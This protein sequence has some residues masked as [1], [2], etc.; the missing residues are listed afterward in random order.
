MRFKCFL[1]AAAVLAVSAPAGATFHLMSIREVYVGPAID[2]NA[3]Y[4]MLQMYA[5]DQNHVQ[6][7]SVTFYGPTGTLVGTRTFPS[8]LNNGADQA[9]ILIATT[10]AATRFGVIADLG[11]TPLLDPAGG[12]VCFD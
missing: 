9:Y 2:A 10:E 4:V 6:G 11:M 7:H 3:Q 5:A 8:D 12:K 1:L